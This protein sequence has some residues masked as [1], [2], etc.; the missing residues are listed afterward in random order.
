VPEKQTPS[1]SSRAQR[2]PARPPDLE[3]LLYELGI[4]PPG[5]TKYALVSRWA[6][7]HVWRVDVK[8]RPWAFIR[9]LLG[10][11][12]RYPDRWRHL[13]LSVELFEAHIGPRVLGVTPESEAL[14][15]RAAIVESAL[16]AISRDELED[17]PQD[18]IALLARLHSCGPLHAALSQDLTLADREGFSPIAN[19]FQETNE[20]WLE[21]V[22]D[23]WL[24]ARIPYADQATDIVAELL[25]ALESIDH[26][27]QRLNIVVP[28]HNDPNHGNFMINRSGALRMID[29]EGL[30]LSNPV[31]DLGIFL[32]WYVD[33]D[34]HYE[35]LT[36]YPLTE[37]DLILERMKVWVPLRYL[38][39]AA[40]WA[41]RLSRARDRDG[42]EFAASSIDEWLRGATE[43][44]YNGDSPAHLIDN[45]DAFKQTLLA[46]DMPNADLDEPGEALE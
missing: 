43:L 46:M 42:W 20:R 37:P 9:Y 1:R 7:K 30:A 27:S 29:F 31:A 11:A 3:A 12:D 19:L 34:R 35:V 13:R 36:H 10:P 24:E 39:L 8:G 33:R 44:L 4:T 23:R 15:G 32:T 6:A 18:A 41:G 22:P 5:P 40:H 14:S 45:L 17:E 16:T 28:A 2:R 26:D 21:A 38:N 25:A